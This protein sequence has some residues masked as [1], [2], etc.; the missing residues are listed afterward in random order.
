MIFF[1]VIVLFF[2][3]Q[4]FDPSI[5]NEL[6]T[7]RSIKMNLEAEKHAY[8]TERSGYHVQCKQQQDEIQQVNC[9]FRDF[10]FVKLKL[11]FHINQ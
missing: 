8:E 1:T 7:L 2:I 5:Y 10:F 11:K 4:Q 3:F 6:E 9:N